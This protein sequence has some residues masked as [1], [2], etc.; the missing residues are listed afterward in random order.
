MQLDASPVPLAAGRRHRRPGRSSGWA[1]SAPRT[2]RPPTGSSSTDDRGRRLRHAG[3][4]HPLHGSP[5]ATTPRSTRGPG[6]ASCGRGALGEPLDDRA[7]DLPARRLAALPGHRPDGRGR[8]RHLASARPTSRGLGR[9]RPVRRRQRRHPDRHRLQ[10]HAHLRRPRRRRRPRHRPHA[11]R[12]RRTDHARPDSHPGARLPQRRRGGRVT[13]FQFQLRNPNY[14]GVAASLLDG[15]E[16][17]VDGERV[18]DH[19]PLWTLQGR[20]FTL[21]ELRGLDRRP[22]AARRAGRPSPCPS[23]AGSRSACT[24]SRSS[25]TCAGPYF[26]PMVSRT[27]VHGGRA[28][29]SSCRRS[30]TAA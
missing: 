3:D 14:R 5:S 6:R 18:P 2:C 9:R 23:P 15:I 30:R 7:A 13:G 25:S 16:V 29:A 1:G 12:P 4:A 28:R 20:T 26:P 8:R 11:H 27:H 10:P 22:L 24:G 21:D 19:V 17:V